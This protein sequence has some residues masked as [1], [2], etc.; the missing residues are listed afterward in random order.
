MSYSDV[1]QHKVNK[2]DNNL[3]D[4]I[5]MDIP[6][7]VINKTTP[8]LN[9]DGKQILDKDG[10]PEMYIKDYIAFNPIYD[11]LQEMKKKDKNF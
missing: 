7:F 6:T 11:Y 8:R 2:N 1:S 5:F 10:N 4:F 3:N 9:K